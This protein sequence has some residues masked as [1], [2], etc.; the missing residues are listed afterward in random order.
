MSTCRHIAGRRPGRGDLPVG[1]NFRISENA[2]KPLSQKYSGF[3]KTQISFITPPSRPTPK[4]RFA[5]VTDVG[6]GMR[7][8]R[9]RCKTGS[10]GAD[11]EVVWSR[12]PDAGVR[13]AGKY[14]AADGGKK[15]RSPGRAR[16][17]P[18]KPLRGECRVSPV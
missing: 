13:S 5:I 16:R 8:T 10:V 1:K 15:D 4:G 17:K 9:M 7:W 11:G 3:Q 6:G 14:P 18:L 12:H 2:V